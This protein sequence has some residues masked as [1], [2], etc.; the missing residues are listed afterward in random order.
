MRGRDA[1]CRVWTG[2]RC[3]LAALAKTRVFIA[4]SWLFHE[5]VASKQQLACL[6]M[7]RYTLLENQERNRSQAEPRD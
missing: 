6:L 4:M 1:A 7:G 5:G 3:D 2:D